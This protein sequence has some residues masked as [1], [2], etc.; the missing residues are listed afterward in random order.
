MFI[1]LLFRF[2]CSIISVI[3]TL[4]EA[5]TSG[6]IELDIEVSTDNGVNWNSVLATTP[7]VTTSTVGS[8]SSSFSFVSGGEVLT[9]ND[10]YR[11]QLVQKQVD[12][13]DFHV[14]VYGD[15]V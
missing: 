9:Q 6:T 10:L 12:Q 4:L 14:S 7:Q 1:H 5:S 8:I 15:L 13:G 11:I 2:D 3:V